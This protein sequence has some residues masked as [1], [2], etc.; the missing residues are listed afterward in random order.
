VKGAG[1]ITRATPA[2]PRR[3]IRPALAVI[4]AALVV[5]AAR[6]GRARAGEIDVPDSTAL[7]P[8]PE[9]ADG[10]DYEIERADSLDDGR[11]EVGYSATGYRGSA[12]RR[13]RRVRFRGDGFS[14]AV[15]DGAGDPLAG[16]AIDA[17]A[18]GG[19]LRVGRLAPRWGR[20]L[21]IGAPAEPWSRAA[22]DRGAGARFV[23]RAGDGF[24][25]RRGGPLAIE[26]VAGRF[27]R[28]DL[29]GL[30]VRAGVASAGL[31]AAHGG[32]GQLSL[33]LARDA[34]DGELALDRAGRWRAEAGSQRALGRARLAGHVRGGLTGFRSLAEPLRSGPAQTAA[35][36]LA[37]PVG[38]ARIVALG[39]LWRLGPGVGGA[40]G[41]L[42]VSLALA[43]HAALALGFEEQHGV[44]RV[45]AS[46]SASPAGG[47]RQ[48]L[49][50]EWHGGPPGMSLALRQEAWGER[51]FARGAVRAA[52][53]VRLDVQGPLGSWFSVAQTAYRVRRGESLY[54]A[55]AE[56]DRLVL[57]S[58]TGAGERTRI[59]CRAAAGGGALRAA[60]NLSTAALNRPRAQWVLDWT[61]RARAGNAAPRGP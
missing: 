32:A 22:S 61:R 31:L 14:G 5:L 19:A 15:R 52:T 23:G 43:Q 57:R 6:H 13:S 40:R 30:R 24:A 47:F 28:R 7:E 51:R 41:A 20:G 49:W 9:S 45:S 33:G 12:P 56:S 48:G 39:A 11:V 34:S 38:G 1:V 29:A 8:P 37:A 10:E 58:L 42:E 60:L 59:E 21:V 16:S 3:A 26:S 17:D 2:R 27:S 46:G 55:E 54:L 25:F 18:L 53:A 36:T 44:R 4:A 35:V 50:G